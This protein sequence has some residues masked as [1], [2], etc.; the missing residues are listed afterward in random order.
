MVALARRARTRSPISAPSGV[1]VLA[2][3]RS[4]QRTHLA[5][6]LAMLACRAGSRPAPGGGL[7]AV[8]DAGRT[9]LLAGPARRVVSLSP[10]MTELLFAL[11]A[12]DRLVGRTTWCDYP[13]AARA[14]PSVGDGLNPNV[15][16]VAARRPDLVVL[17]R[18]PLDAGAA[19]ALERLGIAAVVLRQDRLADLARAAALLGRLTGEER[20]GDSLAAALAALGARPAPP[21]GVRLAFVMWDDPPVVIGAG[22]YLDE[23][24]TLA[25]ATNVFHDL[26]AA[27]AG[28]SLE[29]LAARDPDVIAVLQD[30]GAPALPPF[31]RRP[32]WQAI[33]AVRARRVVALPGSLFGRP[34]PR[35][36]LAAAELRRLLEAVPR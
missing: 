8:D 15:E 13:P 29:T 31:A 18:S 28:V 27:S 24:A 34:S 19:R 14:V 12:G 33:R 2:M 21:L 11:G 26:P 25:G 6:L 17:Y 32:E 20:A 1:G 4:A 35:A 5:V 10:A 30:S 9:V 22:S 23:L 16:M 3:R 36:A 7:R